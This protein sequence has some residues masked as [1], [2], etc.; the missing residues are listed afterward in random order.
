MYSTLKLNLKHFEL[1]TG[2]SKIYSL[3][4]RNL[5]IKRNNKNYSEIGN[6]I[7]VIHKIKDKDNKLQ[8]PKINLEKSANE[9]ENLL[10]RY[11]KYL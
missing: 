2:N 1:I 8:S 3:I 7:N 11:K 10:K 4:L 6:K 9:I 5:N